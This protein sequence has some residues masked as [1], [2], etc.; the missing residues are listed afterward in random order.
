MGRHR[1]ALAPRVGVAIAVLVGTACS[2]RTEAQGEDTQ[3]TQGTMGPGSTSNPGT[4]GAVSSEGGVVE[5]STSATPA[6]SSSGA[7][8]DS[9]ADSATG[10]GP[11]VVFDVGTQVDLPPMGV[12]ES[13]TGEPIDCD[14]VPAGPLPYV[15]IDGPRASEDLAFDHLG[16]LIGAE[17]GNLFQSPIDA[18]PQLWIPGVSGGFVAG[19]RATSDGVFVLADVN[20]GSLVRVNA[21]ASYEVVL[22]GFEYPNGMDV[23]LNGWVYVA[24][25]SGSRVRRIDA[26][27]GDFTVVAEGLQAPNGVSFSPDYQTLYVGSFGGGTVT[28]V[29]L[30]PDMTT[31][32]VELFRANIGG[33]ALDGM[34]VDACGN[35][36]VCEYIAAIVWRISPDGASIE[37]LVQLGAETSWIPNLQFGSGYGGWESDHLYVL[38]ISGDRVF[39]IDVGVPDKPRAYP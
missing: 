33:G 38:D 16:N 12:G 30:N 4:T 11:G 23:D 2:D 10:T 14:A 13:S 6:D 19:L 17:Q 15:V 32:S 24:E 3:G 21:D 27:T 9:S 39:D 8:T 36:Y 1:I 34:A 26:Q 20:S 22:G 5:T 18:A 7:P 29:H 28:A 37:Q 35:V 31:D 25:Q